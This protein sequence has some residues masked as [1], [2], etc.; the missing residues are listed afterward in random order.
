MKGSHDV[1]QGCVAHVGEYLDWQRGTQLQSPSASPGADA[2]V[3]AYIRTAVLQVAGIEVNGL[4]GANR[5]RQR[6]QAVA[7]LVNGRHAY[8]AVSVRRIDD[9]GE[10]LPPAV[11]R[12]R[13][14]GQ[15]VR[16]VV[17]Q[18]GGASFPQRGHVLLGGVP[19][20]GIAAQI[21]VVAAAMRT[22]FA[23]AKLHV[24]RQGPDVGDFVVVQP[25]PFQG[26]QA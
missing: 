16:S 1:R 15:Q 23:G 25:K 19:V 2:G 20:Q 26:V 3:H 7:R 5:Q 21:H 24:R 8:L 4:A 18:H 10:A 14:D 13:E 22:D 6:A 17:H 12:R 9:A 11:A